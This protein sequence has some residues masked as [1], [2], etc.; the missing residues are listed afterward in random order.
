MDNKGK[1]KTLERSKALAT[2]LDSQFSF[3]GFKFGWDGILGLIPGVGDLFT[4]MLSFYII[5]QAAL[6]GCSPATLVRMTG[7]IVVENIVDAIPI[8]GNLFDFIWKANLK[9]TQLME[10]HLENPNRLKTQSR[11]SIAAL[12]LAIALTLA[13]VLFAAISTLFWLLGLLYNNAF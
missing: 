7:N 9:N 10:R 8:I 5:V 4:T 12:L 13:L 2:F 1:Q 6:I 3:L 11:V